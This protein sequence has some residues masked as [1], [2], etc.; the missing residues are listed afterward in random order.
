WGARRAYIELAVVRHIIASPG[1][2]TAEP[3]ERR[4]VGCRVAVHNDEVGVVSGCETAG[5]AIETEGRRRLAGSHREHLLR[6]EPE[7]YQELEAADVLVV[8]RVVD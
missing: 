1:D 6:A 4:D 8:R 5:Y 2:D 7:R 3:A